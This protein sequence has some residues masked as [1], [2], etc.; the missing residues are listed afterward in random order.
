[1]S[2]VVIAGDTSGTVTLQAPAVAGTT[3]LSLPSTSGTLVTTA[4]GTATTATNLASGSAG[5]VPYQTGSGTTGFTAVGTSGQFLTSAGAGA[6]T[7]STVSTSGGATVTNPM[8]ANVTLTSSSNRVQVLTPDAQSRR[9]TLPDATTVSASGGPIFVLQNTVQAY[10]VAVIDS[11]GTNIGWVV[12][13]YESRVYLT[14]TASAT[15]NWVIKTS[16][17]AADAGVYPYDGFLY[18]TQQTSGFNTMC[19][20]GLSADIMVGSFGGGG[21]SIMVS[22]NTQRYAST[23]Q[24]TQTP[25]TGTVSVTSEGQYYFASITSS[26]L[27]YAYYDT[28]ASSL[29]I[30]AV[31]YS[32]S[33]VGTKGTELQIDTYGSAPYFSIM[34]IDATRALITYTNGSSQYAARI[35]TISGTTCTVGTATTIVATTGQPGAQCAVLSTT[36]AH[37]CL[38]AVIYDLTLNLGASTVTVNSSTA[39]SAGSYGVVANTATSS[40]VFFSNG[41]TRVVG[42]VATS[43]GGTITLGTTSSVFIGASGASIAVSM[44]K[45]GAALISRSGT[46]GNNK[47]IAFARVGVSGGV[48][49][50]LGAG[51]FPNLSTAY[52]F[53][54]SLSGGLGLIPST[55][56]DP[57]GGVTYMYQKVAIAGGA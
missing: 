42:S 28:T 39:L 56:Y 9:I 40:I 17:P 27:L 54:M 51:N 38:N 57:A 11:G 45:A 4:G 25:P 55:Y 53:F 46:T 18:G 8:S 16:N 12:S 1:M 23:S 14:S 34:A 13:D 48:P 10:P 29:K 47:Q 37:V 3:V 35:V 15:G 49:V 19:T 5:V 36:L 43:S 30:F 33:A 32:A 24:V 21:Q 2:S 44:V 52:Y 7:W 6:P 22:Y 50:L 26:L 41:S 20:A 31:S